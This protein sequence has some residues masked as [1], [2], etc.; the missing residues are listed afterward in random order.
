MIVIQGHVAWQYNVFV[1]LWRSRG[2]GGVMNGMRRGCCLVL[3]NDLF[4]R[5][6]RV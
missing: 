2:C 3:E 4:V 1:W 6:F 5:R